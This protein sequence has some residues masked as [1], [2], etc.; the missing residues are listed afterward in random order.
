MYD[1]LRTGTYL[2]QISVNKMFNRILIR[3]WY[4]FR[5]FYI[6]K[7]NYF[8]MLLIALVYLVQAY[9]PRETMFL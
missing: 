2:L 7:R 8:N 4:T 1:C 9:F 6:M 5:Y 3:C